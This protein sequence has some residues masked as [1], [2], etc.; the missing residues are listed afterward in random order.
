MQILWLSCLWLSSI[1]STLSGCSVG[2]SLGHTTESSI[3]SLNQQLIFA[4]LNPHIMYLLTY[5]LARNIYYN[6][7]YLLN[8]VFQ[9]TIIYEVMVYVSIHMHLLRQVI[10]SH[11]YPIWAILYCPCKCRGPGQISPLT[12]GV[13][14]TGPVTT[15]PLPGRE[16][17]L[18]SGLWYSAC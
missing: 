9:E 7:I 2:S 3:T 4:S 15:Q 5:C 1:M 6:I 11:S 16:T 13:A 10:L 12:G 17:S 18:G 14:A 8:S